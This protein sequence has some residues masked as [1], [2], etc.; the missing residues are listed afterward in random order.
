MNSMNS[1]IKQEAWRDK[2]PALR[3]KL[4]KIEGTY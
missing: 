1:N 3:Q 4:I 2:I